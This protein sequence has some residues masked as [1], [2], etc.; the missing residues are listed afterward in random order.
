MEKR[1]II[2]QKIVNSLICLHYFFIM[3]NTQVIIFVKVDYHFNSLNFIN[4]EQHIYQYE[5]YIYENLYH[6]DIDSSTYK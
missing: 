4:M 5:K 2:N 6:V 1:K 3:I